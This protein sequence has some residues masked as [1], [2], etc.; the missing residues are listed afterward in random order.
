M[1]PGWCRHHFLSQT[2]SHVSL[3][4]IKMFTP[5]TNP[6]V[7]SQATD[8]SSWFDNGDIGPNGNPN[9][10][11]SPHVAMAKGDGASL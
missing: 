8:M 2:T 6:F 7:K 5:N 1:L 4:P 9:G 10:G 11:V 3:S